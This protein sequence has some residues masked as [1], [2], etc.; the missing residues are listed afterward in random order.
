MYIGLSMT[1]IF[2]PLRSV[3]SLISFLLEVKFLQ[4]FSRKTTPWIFCRERQELLA[5]VAV[6]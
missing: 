4:P 5:V 2:W 6:R 1:L 3:G